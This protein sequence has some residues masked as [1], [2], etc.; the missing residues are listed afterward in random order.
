MISVLTVNYWS[1]ED[2]AMLAESI[3]QHVARQQIELV[4]TNNSPDDPVHQ[5]HGGSSLPITVVESENLGFAAGVNLAYRHSRGE[6]IMIA[7]PDVRVTVGTFDRA[8]DYLAAN[9]Q[10]GIVLPLL[11][12]PTGA[13]QPSVRRF[14]TWRTALYARSPLRMLGYHPAF[15]RRYLCEDIDRSR[16]AHVDWGLG[17][18]MFLRREDCDED[19]IFDERFF[20]YFE[21]V[22][23]C[24]RMWRRGRAAVYC[25]DI[26]CVHAHRRLSRNPFSLSGWQHFR[27]LLRFVAK[28][29][30][31]PQRPGL[32]PSRQT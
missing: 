3:H 23:L 15:F 31:L 4:V 21:D 16:P 19:E 25:P 6:I 1:S 13:I 10:V 27:S 5:L 26:E 29:R 11:R 2:L 12:Y 24:H 8:A 30:G 32:Q 9:P 28:Y 17:A 7:N 14:Y 18:A 22:D 20:M